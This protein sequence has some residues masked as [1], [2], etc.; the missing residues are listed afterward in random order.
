ML[1]AV[2]HLPVER[3]ADVVRGAVPAE[4]ARLA[5]EHAA[6]CETC[7]SRLA[8]AQA[9]A[10][11]SDLPTG[12]V[13]PSGGL[14]T[15]GASGLKPPRS[16]PQLARGTAVGRYVVL[17][18]V[19]Q[20]GMGSV[21]AA[22]DPEL[23]R[24]VALKLLRLDDDSELGR[25]RL[26]REAQ[27]MARLAHPNVVAV[28]DV[29]VHDGRVFITMELVPGITLKEWMVQKPRTWREVVRVFGEAGTGLAA[30]HAAHLVHR[31]FKPANVLV[32][33]DGRV[34]VTDF[35]LAR[36]DAPDLPHAPPQT[37]LTDSGSHQSLSEPL[38]Q[39]GSVVGTLGYMSPEQ[40]RSQPLDPRSDQFSFCVCLWEALYGKR[41]FVAD[42]PQAI[43]ALTLDGKLPDV[44]RTSKVP[45]RLHALLVRGLQTD[46]ARRFGAMEPL[47]AELLKD[48]ARTVRQAAPLGAAALV[49]L[50][51]VAG[52]EL[53]QAR[54]AHTCDGAAQ[55]LQGVWDADV[56]QKLQDAFT[57]TKK[58]YAA[59]ALESSVR[60]L[61]AQAKA[62]VADRTE[63][64]EATRVRAAQTEDVLALR[65]ACLERR[66]G[67][68]KAVTQV[69]SEA[70]APV[71]ERAVTVVYALPPVSLCD[72][73]A[74]LRSRRGDTDDDAKAKALRETVQR[75]KALIDSGQYAKAQALLEPAAAQGQ[76]LQ[77]PGLEAE[78]QLLL[79]NLLV[80]TG[81]F[82]DALKRLQG[83]FDIALAR[84]LDEVA[85]SAAISAAVVAS[86]TDKPAESAIWLEL[87]M[88]LVDRLGGDKRLNLEWL[89]ARGIALR[90]AGKSS[91][92]A[93]V[94]EAALRAATAVQGPDSPLL[95]K[96]YFD[97]G[98]SYVATHEWGKAVPAL[99]RALDIK[100]K[101]QGAEHPEVALILANIGAPYFFSG[102]PQK[103][104]EALERALAV[105][106]QLF[107]P[108]SPKL[109]PVLDNLADI[110]AKSG[111][112]ELARTHLDHALALGEKTLGK[113]HSHVI[114]S[115][116]TL[117]EVEL[118]AGNLDA[119]AKLIDEAIEAKPM[120]VY[121]AEALAIR[122][123]VALKQG[124]P[125][126]AKGFAERAV[127]AGD[128]AGKDSGDV[129]LPLSVMGSTLLALGQPKDALVPLERALKLAQD[130]KAWSVWRGDVEVSLARAL[131]AT[132]NSDRVEGLL[133]DAKAAWAGSP[134]R[135]VELKALEA[136]KSAAR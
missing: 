73:V 74:A 76:S 101:N 68:L 57:A 53:K 59:Q 19:G 129:I 115:R 33:E 89:H 119:A 65:E 49:V 136:G 9:R 20:G 39:V 61:D 98:V 135:E 36:G 113:T 103:A 51:V 111:Q 128:S 15:M 58:P 31:D 62:Y 120:P 85:A 47:L 45:A 72:D 34:R 105:R 32:G 99:E 50:A 10:Q 110:L 16:E 96:A 87:S 95:W 60:G 11:A 123:R 42:S 133:S 90:L 7:G 38:T 127:A 100:V 35:G 78:A 44:P 64:C 18:P 112:L 55:S 86:Q 29:G 131:E 104:R 5:L 23:D 8:L 109:V 25:Q 88:G 13:Y 93:N 125:K 41:P 56:K 67:E 66:L 63:A 97:L 82:P 130:T 134:L 2:D 81:K 84:G 94:H 116:L 30:A 1:R 80:Q 91:E 69:L 37:T 107:G 12:A 83:A 114:V 117:G 3:W 22:F 4:Q 46:P 122:A 124:K 14:A 26:L 27:A 77:R 102:Q 6:S 75:G 118:E 28:H 79:G 24:R 17:D 132:G 108:E 121:L 52:F 40:I 71:V 21:Y 48:P 70:D 106:T 54:A 43:T 126:D 92:A